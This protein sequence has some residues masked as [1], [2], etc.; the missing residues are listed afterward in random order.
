M[1]AQNPL[2]ELLVQFKKLLKYVEEK[3]D[4]QSDQLNIPEDIEE[5][6]KKL[7]TQIDQYKRLGQD[8]VAL[9]GVSQEEMKM[10]LQGVSKEIS[11]EGKELMN[12][13]HLLK[14]ET[15]NVKKK[16][17]KKLKEADLKVKQT[18]DF[19]QWDSSTV[20]QKEEELTEDQKAKKR[21]SK[22]KRFG[23]DKNWKPL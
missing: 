19:S 4:V 17:E 18:E 21:K 22:F 13:V 16:I 3:V 11:P 14:S 1:P 8:V 6:L 23:S 15:D 2:E 7:Q 12:K 9:S 20:V 5:R 10:R